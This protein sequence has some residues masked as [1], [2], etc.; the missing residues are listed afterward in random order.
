MFAQLKTMLRK[1][2]TVSVTVAIE[3]DTQL[4]VNVFP[5]LFTLDGE[6]SDNRKALSTP[7]SIVA[8]PEELDGPAFIETLTK[9]GASTNTLRHTLDEVEET[10]K[11]AA[12]AAKAK[13]A[14]KAA[15]KPVAKKPTPGTRPVAKIADKSAA[16]DEDDED[17]EEGEEESADQAAVDK[18]AEKPAAK[19]ADDNPL[20]L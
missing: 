12:D 17:G 13:P 3:D 18:A 15:G 1:G 19:P 20:G 6:H 5:K 2:D 8:T 9:L 14:A 4:R 10:H 11:K 7:L 16:A